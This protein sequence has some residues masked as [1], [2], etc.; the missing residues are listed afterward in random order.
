MT[1][2]QQPTDLS[3]PS[4]AL[5]KIINLHL[6]IED[7]S[8]LVSTCVRHVTQRNIKFNQNNY[9]NQN[10]IET[11]QILNSNLKI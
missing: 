7:N 8:S 4:R 6:D 11:C 5:P 1:I 2:I 10:Y 9:W 3:C